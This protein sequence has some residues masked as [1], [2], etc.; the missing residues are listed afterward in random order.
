MTDAGIVD[1]HSHLVPGVDDGAPTLED[2]LEGI[3]RMVDRGV[4]RLVTTPHL[5][6][7]VATSPARLDHA[8][9]PVAEAFARLQQAVLARYPALSLG[10]AHEVKLDLPDPDLS[11]PRLRLPGTSVVLVEWPGLQVPPR[12]AEVLG[13]LSAAGIQ[14]LVAHPER[15]RRLG[16]RPELPGEWRE[17]GAWLLVNHGSLVGRY[18]REAEQCAQDLLSRGWVDALATD[19]HGRPQLSLYIERARSW[20]E[21]R[22]GQDLWDLLTRENPGRIADGRAPLPV[23]PLAVGEPGLLDRIRMAFRGAP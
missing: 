12:S 13:E 9:A 8:L 21:R 23:P 5:D 22:G 1:L 6:A 17:A 3:E 4:V 16:A 15:Y 14:P 18:G 11:D 19:F 20:I 2:A 10:L 7:S